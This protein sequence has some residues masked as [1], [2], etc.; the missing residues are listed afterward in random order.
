MC[1]LL[2]ETINDTAMLS[3]RSLALSVLLEA[4]T[5]SQLKKIQR[6]TAEH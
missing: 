3:A 6:P 2:L 4:I 1:P 5:N